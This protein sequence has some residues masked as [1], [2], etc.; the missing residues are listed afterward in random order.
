MLELDLPPSGAFSP[1]PFMK[2]QDL[3]C[4]LLITINVSLRHSDISMIGNY[5]PEVE[6]KREIKVLSLCRSN[7]C[8]LSITIDIYAYSYL[9]RSA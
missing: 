1:L 8:M 3:L 4:L 6:V 2:L 7:V 9:Q 5:K